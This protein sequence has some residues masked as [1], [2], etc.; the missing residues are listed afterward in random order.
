[1]PLKQKDE[2]N[3]LIVIIRTAAHNPSK[4]KQND[5]I[6]VGRMI[7]DYLVAIDESISVYGI[8]AIFGKSHTQLVVQGLIIKFD[9]FRHAR[10]RLRTRNANDTG[11]YQTRCKLMGVLPAAN[12]KAGICQH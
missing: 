11:A 8:R 5:V 1:M 7:L 6:K 9:H 12:P 10:N 3:R 4:H 2:E